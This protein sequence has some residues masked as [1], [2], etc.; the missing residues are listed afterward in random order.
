MPT[1][2]YEPMDP[3]RWG[4]NSLLEGA[5][6]GSEHGA[7]KERGREHAA[8][9][10]AREGEGGGEDLEQG[11]GKEDLPGELR[12]HGLIDGLVAGSHDLR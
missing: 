12:V 11:E 9:R 4:K 3:V 10:A 6:G 7:D 5:D 2:A 1:S 8:G